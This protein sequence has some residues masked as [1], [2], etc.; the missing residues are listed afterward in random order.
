MFLLVLPETLL[1]LE[2]NKSIVQTA[3]FE[4]SR[5]NT[6]FLRRNTAPLVEIVG[7]H[8]KDTSANA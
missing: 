5:A 3:S 6:K 4:S 8:S 7:P 2:N 1:F